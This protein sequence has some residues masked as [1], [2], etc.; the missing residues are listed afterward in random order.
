MRPMADQSKQRGRRER[1]GR[2]RV[3][4][5]Q[6][7]AERRKRYMIGGGIIGVFILVIVGLTVIELIGQDDEEAA[8][9]FPPIV[10]ASSSH[11][12]V[13]SEPYFLGDPDAPVHLI[14]WSDYQ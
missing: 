9:D 1:R 3:E 2:R 12:N 5:E 13:P 7:E 14:E 8:D 4:R 11:D 10:A 6:K